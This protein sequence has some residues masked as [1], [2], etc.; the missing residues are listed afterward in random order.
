MCV[1]MR[2]LLKPFEVESIWAVDQRASTIYTIGSP[3]ATQSLNISNASLSSLQ[4]RDIRRRYADTLGPQRF[5]FGY[6]YDEECTSEQIYADICKPIVNSIIAGY[7]GTILMYGQTTSGKTYTML[8][9]PGLPGILP[10][11]I[12]DI[13]DNI[14]KNADYDNSLWVSYLEIYN[15]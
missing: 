8:G 5:S 14:T 1:R 3:Y 2:P 6:V 15:E 4:E 12:L 11:A 9:T 13:F 10:C 7:N